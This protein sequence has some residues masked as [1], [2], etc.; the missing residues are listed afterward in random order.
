ML[1]NINSVNCTSCSYCNS[2]DAFV[3]KN[4]VTE[5]FLCFDCQRHIPFSKIKT[6]PKE[7]QRSQV[8]FNPILSLCTSITSLSSDHF[9]I[10]Y[11][12]KR[13]IKETFWN[14]LYF[15]EKLDVIA[16]NI[17][18]EA[19]IGPRLIIPFFDKDGDLFALQGR[20]LDDSKIRYVTLVFDKSKDL[21]FG[22]DRVDLQKPF[23]VVEGPIDSL[24][25]ENAVATAGIGNVPDKY[26]SLATICLDNEPRNKDIVK[27]IKKNIERGFKVVIWPD[28][29]KQKDINDM[30]LCG[31]NVEEVIEQNTFKNMNAMIRL[32]NWKKV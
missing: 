13:K 25:L 31:V 7:T 29:I 18:K 22:T 5:M 4:K 9:A 16:K 30:F 28:T 32:N 1:P 15:T 21:L 26:L 24:F 19:P 3:Y 10:A 8:S 23:V 27:I 6:I 20:A 12:K 14:K 11:L 2:S 17:G